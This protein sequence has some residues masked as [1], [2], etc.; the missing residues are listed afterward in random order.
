MITVA[1]FCSSRYD[2]AFVENSI[3]DVYNG[4]KI[5]I[6]KP[7]NPF[8]DSSW[9][10]DPFILD[11]TDSFIYLLVEVVTKDVSK[12]RIAKLTIDRNKSEIT[13]A[14]IILE[15]PWHLSFPFIIRK[16]GKIF[17]APESSQG[18]VLYL[19]ELKTNENGMEKLVRVKKLC[20]D[21][22]WDSVFLDDCGNTLMLTSAHNDFSLDFYRY[23]EKSDLYEYSESIHSKKQNMRMAGGI[24]KYNDKL[25]CPSQNSRPG[26]YGE[27]T[28]LKELKKTESGWQLHSIRNIYP[29]R[30]IL[31]DGLHTFNIYK[32]LIVVDIHRQNNLVSLIINK[33]VI[34]K[35]RIFSK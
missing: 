21:V 14:E 5:K 9:F 33:M 15:E 20:D 29:P 6:I 12:G 2:I 19:Y 25:I 24:F 32:D 17:V 7:T 30:G 27:Y 18:H 4:C 8:R 28:E 1:R 23:D 3:N 22:V 16:E 31:N 10:A 35:K 11:V 26:S 34:I 13:K